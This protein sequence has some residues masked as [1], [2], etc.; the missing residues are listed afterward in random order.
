MRWR[1][2]GLVFEPDGRSWQ[3]SH[4]ATPVGLPLGDDTLRVYFSSRDERNR[5]HV[6]FVELELG[7]DIRVTRVAERPVLGPGPLGTFDDHGVYGT[8]IVEHDGALWMYY[9]GWNPGPPPLYY[10][11]IGVALSTDG[12]E[13]FE[14][15]SPAPIMARSEFDPWMVSAP[16]V[17][18]DGELWR[19]WHIS[20]LS[21]AEERGR[22]VSYYHLKYAESDDGLDWRRDGRVAI[23]LQ[24]GERNIARMCVR[25]TTNGYE[26]WYSFSGDNGYR[27]GRAES[28]DGYE[29]TRRDQ[30]AGLE[31]SP[32]GWDSEAIAYPFVFEHRGR[33]WMLYNGNGFGRDGFGL[34]EEVA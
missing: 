5:S 22:L 24:P 8:S 2:H 15:R 27:I 18:R 19:M 30:D 33:R 25:R 21:W 28:P 31:V 10:P 12:G 11:S 20:G 23:E 4:A 29:W 32:E 1:K 26:G 6:G 17:L 7:E 3:R 16:F 34:A 14:R 13:S 9:M